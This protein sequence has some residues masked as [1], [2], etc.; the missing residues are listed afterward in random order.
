M[1]QSF[2]GTS[3]MRDDPG[4]KMRMEVISEIGIGFGSPR[5]SPDHSLRWKQAV[6]VELK[7]GRIRFL[8]SEITTGTDDNNNQRVLWADKKE[9]EA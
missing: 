5:I 4:S 3:N 8:F 2:V 9:N 6:L 7:Q 1:F